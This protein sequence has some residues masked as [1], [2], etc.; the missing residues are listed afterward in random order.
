MTERQL[1]ALP[2]LVIQ[3]RAAMLEYRVYEMDSDRII[4]PAG[5]FG[6][7]CRSGGDREIY[8][9]VQSQRP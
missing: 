4:G 3:Q 5:A 8:A 9:A 2:A 7:R 1:S 6:V